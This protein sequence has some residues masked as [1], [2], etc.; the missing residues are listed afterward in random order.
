VDKRLIGHK[1]WVLAGHRPELSG[2]SVGKIAAG[3]R[4][5]SNSWFLVPVGTHVHIY[6]SKLY[7]FWYGDSTSTT[8]RVTNL[9]FPPL[10]ST[11]IFIPLTFWLTAKLLLAL[12]SVVTLRYESHGTHDHILFSDSSWSPQRLHTTH[13]IFDMIRIVQETPHSFTYSF[14]FFV[15]CHGN[16]LN[17]PLPRNG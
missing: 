9:P 8:G 15:Q 14:V 12:A 10:T 17:D 11:Y 7:V 5:H 1:F 16:V 6:F 3:P 13:C 2:R 4:Q